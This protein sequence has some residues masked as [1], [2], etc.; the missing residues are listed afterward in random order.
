MNIEIGQVFV[1]VRTKKDGSL[2]YRSDGVV[3]ENMTS[4]SRFIL[5]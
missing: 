3:W 2:D 1:I 4:T 5:E